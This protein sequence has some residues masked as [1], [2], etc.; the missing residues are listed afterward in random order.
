MVYGTCYS[1]LSKKEELRDLG[2]AGNQIVKYIHIFITFFL[3][4]AMTGHLET[5][6]L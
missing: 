2:F 5:Y 4:V 1:P 3:Q 6:R